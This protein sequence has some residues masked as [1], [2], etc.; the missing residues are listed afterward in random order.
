MKYKLKENV[1]FDFV[2]KK[3]LLDIKEIVEKA[4]DNNYETIGNDTNKI[5]E[6]IDKELEL[7]K[8]EE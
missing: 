2:S 3:A 7:D 6:I 4:K 5:I 1:N 8:V